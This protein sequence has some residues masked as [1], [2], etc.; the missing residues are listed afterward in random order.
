MH[1]AFMNIEFRE[2]EFYNFTHA[3]MIVLWIYLLRA[4]QIQ[5]KARSVSFEGQRNIDEDGTEARRADGEGG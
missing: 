1:G 2:D 5:E 4:Q 3:S